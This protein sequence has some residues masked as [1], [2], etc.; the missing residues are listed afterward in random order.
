MINDFEILTWSNNFKYPNMVKI[1]TEGDGS[2]FFHAITNSFYRPYITGMVGNTPLDKKGFIRNLRTD[3]SKQLKYHYKNLSRG[4]LEDFSKG[5]GLETFSLTEMEK[6][7]D[8]NM[9]VDNRFNEYV[10]NIIDKDIYILDGQTQDVYI[11][12]KDDDI[13]YKRRNSIVL[14]YSNNHYELVGVLQ[15]GIIKTLFDYSDPF[16]MS[17]RSRLKN[18]TK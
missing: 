11:T 14:L 2:C 17:I 3:L 4:K 10:S 15:T 18:L 1:Y 5:E 9:P 13:L 16:I 6:I 12:G 8:S 7:L